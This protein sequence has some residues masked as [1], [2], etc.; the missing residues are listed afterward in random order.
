VTC[1]W[2]CRSIR[3]NRPPILPPDDPGPISKPKT[4]AEFGLATR[5]ARNIRGQPKRRRR[6]WGYCQAQNFEAEM[7]LHRIKLQVERRAGEILM[8]MH[9]AKGGAKPGFGR[10]GTMPS[11]EIRALPP[12]NSDLG[13]TYRQSSSYQSWPGFRSPSSNGRSRPMKCRRSIRS[14]RWKGACETR[15]VQGGTSPL[16]AGRRQ[17]RSPVAQMPRCPSRPDPQAV[18][19]NK[20]TPAPLSG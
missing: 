6:R 15:A 18:S 12:T 1:R 13:I 9:K 7:Q 8:K 16:T 5:T 3:G 2:R 20:V 11:P 4:I 14:S 19:R 17:N 10:R